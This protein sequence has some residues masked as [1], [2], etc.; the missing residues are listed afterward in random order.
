VIKTK[1]SKKEAKTIIN[2]DIV[3]AKEKIQHPLFVKSMKKNPKISSTNLVTKD[4]V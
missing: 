2:K 1:D 4:K 3:K